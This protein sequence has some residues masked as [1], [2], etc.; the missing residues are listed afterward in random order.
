M[1][2]EEQRIKLYL[3][4][5]NL[6]RAF[7][8]HYVGGESSA[9]IWIA[10]IEV[11]STINE[12]ATRIHFAKELAEKCGLPE[13]NL[14]SHGVVF[15]WAI[16]EKYV[17]H[18]VSLQTLMKREFQEYRFLQPST[19]EVRRCTAGE[20]QQHGLWEMGNGY[21]PGFLCTKVWS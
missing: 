15:E 21:Y 19:A 7:D 16:P 14:F 18:E 4:R 20:L 10:F 5:G 17:L 6:K 2:P 9:D 12:T 13:R 1:Q 8:K 3:I 11:P